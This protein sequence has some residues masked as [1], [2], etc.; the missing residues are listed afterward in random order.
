MQTGLIL[1]DDAA[2]KRLIKAVG[3]D[4][5]LILHLGE[6]LLHLNMFSD[7]QVYDILRFVKSGIAEFSRAIGEG[8]PVS[9]TICVCD[10]Q[11]V[12]M[13]GLPKFLDTQTSEEIEELP[14][15]AVTHIFCDL[16]ALWDRMQHRQGRFHATTRN[17]STDAATDDQAGQL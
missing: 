3:S 1:L 12:S 2:A 7:A 10:S 8:R 11:W 15:K 5:D 14:H 13:S 17:C 4:M 6:W 9:G 16:S